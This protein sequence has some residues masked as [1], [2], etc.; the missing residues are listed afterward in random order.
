MCGGILLRPLSVLCGA[1]GTGKT[2]VVSAIIKAVKRVHGSGTPI[3][4]LA[5]TGK[6]ADRL[7]ERT[8]ESAST[9]HSFLAKLG[10]LNDNMTLK[11]QGW[12]EGNGDHHLH[13]RRKLHGR[14]FI[15]GYVLR[16]V[17]LNT[18]QRLIMVG[19]PNQ[20]PPIGTGK[21][22]A[23]LIDWLQGEMPEHVGIADEH[24]AAHQRALRQR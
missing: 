10:R 13:Y 4:L 2:T 1:A 5:P 16:A 24:A 19:D 21:V 7:H 12:Q 8:G 20:L 11:R 18:V 22:F 14:S 3:Q 15:V 6:A 9:F 23:D 17:N